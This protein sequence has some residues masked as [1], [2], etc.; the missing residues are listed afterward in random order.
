MGVE[1]DL[2]NFRC[3]LEGDLDCAL[4]G[5]G[6][7]EFEIGKGKF[8]MTWLYPANRSALT[9]EICLVR[10]TLTYEVALLDLRRPLCSN[11]CGS[12]HNTLFLLF[13]EYRCTPLLQH[14]SNASAKSKAHCL[15]ELY[16]IDMSSKTEF[17]WLCSLWGILIPATL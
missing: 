17:S 2:C 10:S 11:M 3:D 13:L 4:E 14:F 7:T 8:I 6:T 15:P 1:E 12:A 16:D 5:K 9:K